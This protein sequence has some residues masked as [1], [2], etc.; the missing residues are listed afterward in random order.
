MST[1]A[2]SHAGSWY[3]ANGPELH[4]QLEGWLGKVDASSLGYPL[5]S[6]KA[7]IGPFVCFLS[8]FL[9]FRFSYGIMSFGTAMQGS[10]IAVL[11]RLGRTKLS[12]Q[13]TCAL[14]SL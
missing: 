4:K 10:R 1:R 9:S 7:I 8:L 13:R 11:Q 6:L 3:T 5:P 2:A 12:T 14:H